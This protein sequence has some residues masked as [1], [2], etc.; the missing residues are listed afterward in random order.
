MSAQ[1]RGVAPLQCLCRPMAGTGG[2]KALSRTLGDLDTS[3]AFA[4]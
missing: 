4:P 2:R 1:V 3:W